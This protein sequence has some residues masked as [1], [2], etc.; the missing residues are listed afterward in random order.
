MGKKKLRATYVSKGQ[1]NSVNK[2]ITK[3]IRRDYMTTND[4]ILNQLKAL[5]KGKRVVFT[6][7]NSN[8]NNTKERFVKVVGITPQQRKRNREQIITYED[9]LL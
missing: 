2:N 1:R 6:V 8:P 3:A 4:R 5:E 7:P 9:D